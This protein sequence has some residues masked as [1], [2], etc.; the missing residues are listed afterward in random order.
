MPAGATETAPE[1]EV[2]ELGRRLERRRHGRHLLARRYNGRCGLN[3]VRHM[4][5]TGLPSY[6]SPPFGCLN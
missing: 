3:I 2:R 1:G 6:P 4:W 5:A